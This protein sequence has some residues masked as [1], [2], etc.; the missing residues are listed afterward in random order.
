M[1][2]SERTPVSRMLPKVRGLERGKDG[3]TV[4]DVVS[5]LFPITFYDLSG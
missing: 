3:E 1:T 2:A 4:L 5:P